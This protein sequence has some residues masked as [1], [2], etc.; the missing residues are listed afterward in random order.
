MKLTVDEKGIVLAGGANPDGPQEYVFSATTPGIGEPVT[1]LRLDA[2]ADA[3]LPGKGPGRVAHGNFVLTEVEATLDG[4]PLKWAGASADFTQNDWKPEQ[5][6]DGNL[7]PKNGWAI[8]PQMGKDHHVI[9][10]LKTPLTLGEGRKLSVKL[11]Q[12]YGQQHALGK[13]QIRL[14]TGEAVGQHPEV[15]GKLLSKNR[16]KLNEKEMAK[17]RDHFFH[18][19]HEPTRKLR[20]EQEKLAKSAPKEPV[21]AFGIITQRAQPRETKLLERGQFLSPGEKVSAGVPTVLP[22]IQ[23]R[24]PNQLDRLDLAHWLMAPEN[25]LPLRVLAN[26]VW[27]KLFGHGLVRT[28]ND[29][30]VR[31]ELPEYPDLLDWLGA[32]FRRLGWSRKALIRMIVH[33]S[34]YQQASAHREDLAVRD[35][36]NLLLARQNRFRVEAEIT[37]DLCLSI[38]GLLSPKVGGPSV[39]PPMPPEIAALSYANNFKWTNSKGEDRYRR[40]MYTYFKRTAPHPNLTA[41]DCPD[42]NTTSVKRGTSNT[43]LQA[44]TMLNNEVY[45]ETARA[46]AERIA[47]LPAADDRE[48]VSQALRF[49]IARVPGTDEV[50]RFLKLLN[51]SRAW[52]EKNPEASKELIGKNEADP[53]H[54]GLGD[55][56]PRRPEPGRIDH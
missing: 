27:E 43:P 53:G 28:M 10:R 4:Q 3:A 34:A 36:N 55:A 41:F 25:S 12:N 1:A 29:F 8:A 13:F 20:E 21:S 32:E 48:R 16:E 2:L 35:P 47:R 40:G 52:Y 37:R 44:L 26:Q 5:L 19:L 6:I 39:F 38:S 7:D 22:K 30:G 11:I 50:E 31:G 15:I 18:T 23:G 42:S 9:L 17:L 51:E 14:M 33:S 56:G 46:F 24:N 54:G 45:F 49:C